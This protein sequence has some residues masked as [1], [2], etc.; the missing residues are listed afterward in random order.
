[1]KLSDIGTEKIRL[2]VIK[3]IQNQDLCNVL[4]FLIHNE[5]DVKK[6]LFQ[7]I[8]TDGWGMYSCDATDLIMDYLEKNELEDEHLKPI[9]FTPRGGTYKIPEGTNYRGAYMFGGGGGYG[10]QFDKDGNEIKE[11]KKL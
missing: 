5:F 11:F 6:I 9:K 10:K 3:I 2:R 4:K 1:M 7:H 8:Y